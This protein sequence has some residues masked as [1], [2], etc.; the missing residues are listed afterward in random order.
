M[1][2]QVLAAEFLKLRHSRVPQVSL[3]AFSLGPLGVGLF[4]W[5]AAEP[6]R[7]RNLGLIGAKAGLMG[8]TAT[9]PSFLAMFAEVVG[10]GGLLL[11]AFVVAYL[12][13]REYAEGTAKVMLTS[14]A[15]RHLFVLAKFIVAA[16]W[17]ACIVA[18]VLIEALIIGLA[19]A[20]PGLTAA[21]AVRALSQ[22][23]VLAGVAFLLTT[24][25][26][27]IAVLGRG[28]LA[29]LGF[30]VGTLA[31]GD[32]VGHTGWAQWFPWSIMSLLAGTA[33]PRTD[34][35]PAG[36]LVVLVLTCA[37]GIAATMAQLK[38]GDNTQ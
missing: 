13:G 11:L 34:T 10:G 33:G 5:I 29:P 24:L 20:L 22:T 17:W 2:R 35:L 8:L 7:A 12:F 37:L 21:L 14:P 1:F 28:Y 32:L 19:L 15:Q 36:S 38:W 18:G 16:V 9:W 30:A 25:E 31:L 26:G 23:L 3:A 6:G 27:W 4:M